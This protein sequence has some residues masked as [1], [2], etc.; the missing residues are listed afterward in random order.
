MPANRRTTMKQSGKKPPV[1]GNLAVHEWER[2][3]DNAG[4][5][6]FD[7][8]YRPPQEMNSDRISRRRARNKAAMRRAQHVNGT[9]VL[10]GMALAA[11]TILLLL[12]YARLNA[13]SMSIVDM[14]KQIQTLETEQVRLLTEYEQAFDLASVNEKARAAGMTPPSDSQIYYID[15]PGEDQVVSFAGESEYGLGQLVQFLRERLDKA[16]EYFH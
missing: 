14:K 4:Q 1:D 16:L 15:L 11:L 5:M 10:C 2:R 13:I 12:C 8:Q 7:Q 9:T 6:D 3:L